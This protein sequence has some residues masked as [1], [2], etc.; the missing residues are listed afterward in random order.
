MFTIGVLSIFQRSCGCLYTYFKRG[1]R[2]VQY[3]SPSKIVAEFEKPIHIAARDVWPIIQTVRCRFHLGQAWFCKIQIL[4]LPKD[5]NY[6]VILY[7]YIIFA[8][9]LLPPSEVSG[10]FCDYLINNYISDTR[11]SFH[12]QRYPANSKRAPKQHGHDD[13]NQHPEGRQQKTKGT[14]EKRKN[15]RNREKQQRSVYWKY[16]YWK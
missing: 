3:I 2:K 5:Y 8:N 10:W 9:S 7:A 16:I 14:E 6:V 12:H 1:Q 15:S 13:K 4:G 11:E